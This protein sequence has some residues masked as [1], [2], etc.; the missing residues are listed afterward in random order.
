MQPTLPFW[1]KQRQAKLEPMGENTFKVTAPNQGEAYLQIR[2]G[3]NGRWA[4]ALRATPDGADLDVAVVVVGAAREHHPPSMFAGTDAAP[5]ILFDPPSCVF[6]N[7]LP[8]QEANCAFSVSNNGNAD[9]V[10][11]DVRLVSDNF[12]LIVLDGTPLDTL[13]KSLPVTVNSMSRT[14]RFS[15][16]TRPVPCSA[17][18]LLSKICSRVTCSAWSCSVASMVALV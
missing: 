5:Q 10:I 11:D 15:T 9:L 2:A 1:F 13:I 16:C 12:Q 8:G 6:E 14:A 3:E 17:S 7:I 18:P 4:A